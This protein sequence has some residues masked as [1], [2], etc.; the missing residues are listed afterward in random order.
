LFVFIQKRDFDGKMLNALYLSE[1]YLRR[2]FFHFTKRMPAG[3]GRPGINN[4][5]LSIDVK[6]FW[7]KGFKVYRLPP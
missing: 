1:V 3:K 2:F 4:K 7:F 5:A 6:K